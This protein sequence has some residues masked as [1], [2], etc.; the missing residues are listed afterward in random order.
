MNISFQTI[1]WITTVT[2]AIA[3]STKKA[4]H[5]ANVRMDGKENIA[6]R[7]KKLQISASNTIKYLIK[8]FFTNKYKFSYVFSIKPCFIF[9]TNFLLILY[10]L[11]TNHDNHTDTDYLFRIKFHVIC[12]SDYSIVLQI[13]VAMYAC[14]KSFF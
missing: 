8:R 9:H 3:L 13:S 7:Q 2:M 1:I 6:I 5:N 10:F 4:T 11:K 12:M 14:V